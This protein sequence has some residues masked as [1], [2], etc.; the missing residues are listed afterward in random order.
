VVSSMGYQQTAVAGGHVEFD[1]VSR[2][3]GALTLHATVDAGGR[4]SGASATATTF[5]GYELLLADR[6]VRDAIFISSRACGVCG[7]AHALC[8]ALALEMLFEVRPPHFGIAIRNVLAAL[9]NMI[10]HPAHLFLRAGPDFSEPTVRATNPELWTRAQSTAA[11]GVQ[12]HGFRS[13]ADVMTALTRFTG[14]LYKEALAMSR[15][16]R[17]AFV[18]MGGKYPHPQ[19]IVPGGISST[20]DPSDLSLALLRVSKFLDYSRKV[21][22]VWDDLTAFFYEADPRYR[23][24]GAG[25]ANFVDLGLWDDPEYYDGTYERAGGW[26]ERRWATPGA[27]VGGELKT[28]SVHEI[29]TGI[30][31]FVEHSFYEDWVGKG[32]QLLHADPLGNP[33]S[34][35][36]P[37]NKQTLPQPADPDPRGKSTWSTAPRWNGVAM[38]TGPGAR[39]WITAM[40]DRIPNR[41]FMEPT[42]RGMRFGMPQSALPEAV[43]EWHVPREWNAFERNRARAYSLVHATLVA[44]E[45]LLIGFDLARIGGPEARIFNHYAI[46]SDHAIGVGYWGGA[47]G[48]VSHHVEIDR[49][50]IRNYQILAPTTFLTARD[51]TGEPS[52]LEQAVMATPSLSSQGAERHIDLLRAVRSFDPCMS[53]S[54]H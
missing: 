38:E 42:G 41:A 32:E 6:D 16:G 43:L 14:E 17:E 54:T 37:W 36:H 47:R 18:L 28:T 13:V 44:Y 25:P 45:N 34:A 49:K 4:A 23:E 48:Y 22:A 40:A 33:L 20:V 2:V 12:T 21:V 35:R 53:C 9:D 29:D 1:P 50:V 5:R 3:A 46:P 51:A 15:K 52:P 19:T 8:S 24:V 39:L 27:I 11:A 30:E 31:E 10:D 7:A 26:A